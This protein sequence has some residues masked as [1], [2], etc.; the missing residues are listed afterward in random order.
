MDCFN[1]LLAHCMIDL[2]MNCTW[3]TLRDSWL[4]CWRS[5]IPFLSNQ[6]TIAQNNK[7]D[8]ALTEK[9]NLCNA[10]G[11]NETRQ[12]SYSIDDSVND[13]M[14]SLI[15]TKKIYWSIFFL[16]HLLLRE[17]KNLHY[18]WYLKIFYHWIENYTTAWCNFQ[19]SAI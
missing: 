8:C 4:I 12:K 11:K 9:E 18:E 7:P 5:A 6:V 3:T 10:Q 15:M 17:I 14:T 2:A 16:S 1:C 13:K 19:F